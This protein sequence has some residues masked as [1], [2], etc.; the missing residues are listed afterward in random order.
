MVVG[1]SSLTAI[2]DSIIF[3]CQFQNKTGGCIQLKTHGM[4]H[5]LLIQRPARVKAFS[6]P[7]Y[8]NCFQR[9]SGK[10]VCTQIIAIK[11]IFDFLQQSHQSVATV[12]CTLSQLILAVKL[13]V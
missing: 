3:I 7:K 2:I 9:Y 8:N 10:T 13:K 12:N 6:N 4:T 5:Q 11:M 1:K